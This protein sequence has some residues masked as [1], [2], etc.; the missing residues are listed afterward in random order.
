MMIGIAILT[1]ASGLAEVGIGITNFLPVPDYD[2]CLGI[3]VCLSI[4]IRKIGIG[5]LKNRYIPSAL[6]KSNLLIVHIMFLNFD[7]NKI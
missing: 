7:I 5:I 4:G 2:T 1:T 3:G 6:L